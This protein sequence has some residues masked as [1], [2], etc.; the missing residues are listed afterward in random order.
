MTSLAHKRKITQKYLLWFRYRWNN[1]F[2]NAFKFTRKDTCGN[3]YNCIRG[4][5][6]LE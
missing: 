3:K 1:K 4:L 5:W 2:M 6:E